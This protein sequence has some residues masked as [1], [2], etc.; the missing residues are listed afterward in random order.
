MDQT[1]LAKLPKGHKVASPA[2]TIAILCFFLPWIL[3]SC[4]G[5]PIKSFSGWEL[6]A[7]TSMAI[8]FGQA[9][10]IPG[11]PILFLVLL[12]GLGVLALAYFALQRGAA[13]KLDG[14]GLIGLGALPL[15]VL[16]PQLGGQNEA[17]QQGIQIDYQYGLWGVILGYIAVIVGGVLNL[18]EKT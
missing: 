6:A 2:A 13:T 8:G 15:L 12:A 18:K 14:W 11:N 1:K 16:L 17:A 5:Q 3:V 4:S 10:E 7:G 9:Q